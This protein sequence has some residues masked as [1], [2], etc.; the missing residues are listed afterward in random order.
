MVK[1]D[2]ESGLTWLEEA[3]AYAFVHNRPTLWAYLEV[4]MDEVL[5]EMELPAGQNH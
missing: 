2:N 5:F 3:L 4:V 1:V